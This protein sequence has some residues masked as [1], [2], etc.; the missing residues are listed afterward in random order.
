MRKTI[1]AAIAAAAITG[2]AA[3][4]MIQ[5]AA[6][7]PQTPPNPPMPAAPGGMMHGPGMMHRMHEMMRM[8]GMHRAPFAPGTFALFYKQGDR[9]LTAADAQKI[10]EAILLWHGNHAWKVA[11]VVENPDT[12]GFAYA[13]PDGTVIAKFTI[14]RK[15]GHIARVG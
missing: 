1:L 13:A 10:A 8:R 14:D 12:V 6:A 15:N 4:S 3:G 9:H 2:A 5:L 11:D 7:Q